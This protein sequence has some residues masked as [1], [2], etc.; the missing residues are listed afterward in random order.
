MIENLICKCIFSHVQRNF[1]A[2]GTFG[3]KKKYKHKLR[4]TNMNDKYEVPQTLDHWLAS[5]CVS[6]FPANHSGSTFCKCW[7]FQSKNV[8]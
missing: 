4:T 5:V 2:R 1:N 3:T 6:K 7:C 8:T